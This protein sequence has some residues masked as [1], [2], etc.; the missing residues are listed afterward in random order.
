MTVHGD[1]NGDKDE[2]ARHKKATITKRS[3]KK[4][5]AKSERAKMTSEDLDHYRMYGKWGYKR[6]RDCEEC[7]GKGE[8][9]NGEL[10]GNCV[11]GSCTGEKHHC[12]G[13]DA[14]FSSDDGAEFSDGDYDGEESSESEESE[15]DS[16]EA[17]TEKNDDHEFDVRE[18]SFGNLFNYEYIDEDFGTD[19]ANTIIYWNVELLTNIGDRVKGDILKQLSVSAARGFVTVDG[20]EHAL[21]VV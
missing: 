10:C 2:D 13:C 9:K 15:N 4:K 17:D 7:M 21:T 16:S 6:T 5:S 19:D 12:N 11:C 3:T 1:G 14:R 8:H 20:K 18:F